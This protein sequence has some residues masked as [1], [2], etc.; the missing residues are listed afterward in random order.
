MKEESEKQ[1]FICPACGISFTKLY[2]LTRHV[3]SVHKKERLI[4]CEECGKRFSR[5]EILTKHIK[6]KHENSKLSSVYR[7][8]YCPR[9]FDNRRP[10]KDHIR[11]SHT[12]EPVELRK[13]LACEKIFCNSNSL[14]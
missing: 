2:N 12:R 10:F 13:C 5:A 9:I 1:D 14:R 8:E 11:R 3:Q 6:R 4:C 7:C